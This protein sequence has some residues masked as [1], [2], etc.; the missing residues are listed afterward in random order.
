MGSESTPG[1]F[2][3]AIRTIR[4]FLSCRRAG[5]IRLDV[6][7][8]HIVLDEITAEQELAGVDEQGIQHVS[9]RPGDA[10]AKRYKLLMLGAW[11]FLYDA[12]TGALPDPHGTPQALLISTVSLEPFLARGDALLHTCMLNFTRGLEQLQS[13]LEYQP[14]YLVIPEIRSEFAD[15]IRNHLRGYA[16]VKMVDVPLL[17]PYDHFAVLARHLGLRR[18]GGPVWAMRTEGVVAVD[19]C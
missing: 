8:G 12:H 17:Y 6:A 18:S 2:S 7:Q 3:R 13:L 10:A 11:Q 9:R 19:R 4:A 1:T 5:R 15:L 14:I 16:W